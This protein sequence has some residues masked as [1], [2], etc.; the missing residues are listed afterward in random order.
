MTLYY[1]QASAGSGKTYRIQQDVADKLERGELLPSEIMAVTFTKDAAAELKSRISEA[2]LARGNIQLAAGIMSARIGTV[3]SVFGQLLSDFAF[4]LGLSPEQ[5]VLDD[6]DKKQVLAE[7]LDSCLVENEIQQLNRLSSRLCIEEW[8]EDVLKIIELMRANAMH[9]DSAEKFAKESVASFKNYFPAAD[10]SITEASLRAVL[11]EAVKKAKL[12]QSPTRGLTDTIANSEKILRQSAMT[13]QN[14]ISISK[15]KPTKLGEALFAPVQSMALDV[16]RCPAFQHEIA[17]FITLMFQIVQKVMDGFAE[18][19]KSRGLIDFVDQEELA[20]K[21]LHHSLVQQRLTEEVRYL[22]IDEFQDTSPLQLALFSKVSTLIDN[23]LM[24][25]DAKQAIYG[26]R[27]SDPKL[28]LDVLHYVGQGGGNISTLANSWRSRAGLVELTNELFTQ[29]FSHLLQSDQVKL[30]AKRDETLNCAELAWWTLSYEKKN[31]ENILA[32]LAEGIQKHIGTGVQVIDKASHKPRVASWKDLAVL[33]R[34]NKDA[35]DLAG[36]CAQLGIPVSLERTG[37]LE[38]PE[39]SLALA[40]LRR[41]IDPADA[42][43]SAEILTLCTGQNL[44]LWLQDRLAAI[45]AGEANAWNNTAHPL[46][47][48]LD[49]AR[50]HIGLLSTKEAVALAMMAGDV[51]ATVC[52]WRETAKLTE[53]RLA[54]LVRL[55]DMVDDYENHCL[56]QFLAATPTGFILWLKDLEQRF[57]DQ[58]AANPGNAITITT[59]HK[60]KGLEWPIVICSSLDSSLKVSLFGPRITD[61]GLPFDWHKPLNGRSLCYWPYPFPAQKG[62]DIL[63]ERLVGTDEYKSAELQARNEAIQLLYVGMTRARDQLI[64]TT[65]GEEETLGD[66]LQLLNTK[67]LPPE[68]KLITLPS[69]ATLNVE[70]NTWIKSAKPEVKSLNRTRHW[71]KPG[72]QLTELQASDYYRPASK[73]T[74]VTPCSSILLHDFNSR[75]AISG[76]PDMGKVGNV[77]HHCLA[78]I[79]DKPDIDV[80]IL[81]NLVSAETP[82]MLQGEQILR[83]G[84]ALLDWINT[85]YPQSVLHTEMPIMQ[86]LDDGSL[87]QGAIDLVLETDAGWIVIDHKSNPQPK[88]KW[89]EIAQVHSGQLLAYK[90]C[91]ETLSSKPVLAMLIHFSVSG[92]LVKVE[93]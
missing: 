57:T 3:H 92:A 37:L 63:S 11:E 13:W 78:L 5:R 53:H 24:V 80:E 33:C 32:A 90:E 20:L 7:A 76:N 64:L 22:I 55:S 44:E 16:L 26:F 50:Q 8:R 25:G 59:Y 28:A 72:L 14:W 49:K 30:T 10:E 18:I 38:T 1:T 79:L 45:A 77:I 75:V 27:G 58:Q 6:R 46:L 29:P 56:A 48:K 86:L 42:L 31:N 23:V 70:K 84:L 66:W 35:A 82:G 47:T 65:I 4:E 15:F 62:K 54:N 17:D 87:R 39:V 9:S 68:D 73:S 36:Y 83:Q 85:N 74:S 43:A 71:L 41:L 12:V 81:N 61:H 40:C 69:G 21:A 93:L 51:N 34:S 2:L 91:L 88:A 89:L 60:A 19:K 67:V 52:K